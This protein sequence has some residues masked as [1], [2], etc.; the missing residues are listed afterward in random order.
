MTTPLKLAALALGLVAVFGA[1]VGVGSA[2]GPVGPT[3]EEAVA[4]GHD[5]AGDAPVD[6]AV[7]RAAVEEAGYQVAG[8]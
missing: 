3:A 8:S 7:V 4:A 2:V 6:E 1:A 5:M